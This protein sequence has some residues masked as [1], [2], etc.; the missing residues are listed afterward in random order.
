MREYLALFLLLPALLLSGC[1]GRAPAEP[2]PPETEAPA[3]RALTQE[4]VD[5]VNAA[6]ASYVEED[7]VVW[8]TEVNGFF[9]SR[10]ADVRELDFVEFLRYFPGDA[11]LE[12]ADQ[13]EFAALAALPGFPFQDGVEEL[14]WTGPEDLPVPIHR[15]L[16]S[17]VDAALERYAGITTADLADTSG[18]L[19]L[20][21]YDAWY[22]FTSDFGPGVFLCAGGESDGETA[23]LW[24]ETGEDGSREE[25]VLQRDGEDWHI[26]SFQTV[27]GEIVNN[28]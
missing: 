15:I 14:G 18:V 6:Y 21:D 1:A 23:R 27:Q 26:R 11:V 24:T 12:A 25:L 22:T 10:Y 3:A 13:E 17:S 5:Q 20:E 7:N 4:E 9:T 28:P 2:S 16:R 8:S 19:Y